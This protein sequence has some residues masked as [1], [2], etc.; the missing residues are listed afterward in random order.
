MSPAAAKKERAPF[1]SNVLRWARE[2]VR[3]SRKV[4]AKTAGIKPEQIQEWEE[5][6]GI[7]TVQKRL[8]CRL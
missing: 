5:G 4:A 2:R 3:L 6:A 8:A 1:N 7:P